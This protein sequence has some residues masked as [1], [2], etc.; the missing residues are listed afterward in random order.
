MRNDA[1]IAGVRPLTHDTLEVV[2]ECLPGS[3]P[4]LARAGQFATLAVEGVARPRPYSFARDPGAE[5]PGRHTFFIRLV[6]DGEF[7]RWL[8]AGDRTGT[9]VT[10]AGPLG[11]FGLDGSCDP[12]VLIAG[13]SGM[14]AVKAIAE[15]AAREGVER[16][17]YFYYGARTARDLYGARDIAAI[18]DAWHPAGRF[19]FVAVL[20]EEPAGSDWRGP[21]GLVTDQVRADLLDT[22]RVRADGFRAYFCGPPPM[23]EA[24]TAMLTAAGVPAGHLYRDVFEDARSPAPAI[25]NRRCVLCD[26]CLLVRPVPDCILETSGVER[27]PQGRVTV[28]RPVRPAHSSGLYYNALV[29]DPASCIRCYACVSACPHDAISPAFVNAAA[30]LRRG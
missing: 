23:I 1:R 3:K 28:T 21:R 30:T 16:D 7:S 2:V 20:S 8:A 12:M 15:Q 27:D 11:E 6:P 29:I 17:C 24:G 19:T 5:P 22:G 9:P 4:L 25:D 14:S 26:E 13:G 10:I 18:A